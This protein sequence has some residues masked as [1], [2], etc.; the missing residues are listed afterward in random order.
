MVLKFITK[1]K[2]IIPI[3]SGNTSKGISKSSIGAPARIG[4]SRAIPNDRL[5]QFAYDA[6]EKAETKLKERK[7]IN[8]VQNF[9]A[10]RAESEHKKKGKIEQ[11]DEKVDAYKER[12]EKIRGRSQNVKQEREDIRNVLKNLNLEKTALAGYNI[13]TLEDAL[14]LNNLIGGDKQLQ[15]ELERIQNAKI[16]SLKKQSD[17]EAIKLG[18]LYEQKSKDNA[19]IIDET[20]RSLGLKYDRVTDSYVP[21]ENTVKVAQ[22]NLGVE[23]SNAQKE[24]LQ[25]TQIQA[26][27]RLSQTEVLILLESSAGRER[28]QKWGYY[29]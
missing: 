21:D 14:R 10:V 2:T 3:E 24:Q 4:D 15:K 9:E 20:A 27:P 25:Q 6:K 23:F 19:E 5:F 18:K 13:N 29:N 11:L 8:E 26:P 1:N 7:P 12:L 17:E 16:K 28:L 22:E